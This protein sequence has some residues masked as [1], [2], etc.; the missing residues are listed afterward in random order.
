MMG[1]ENGGS[2]GILQAGYCG[3]VNATLRFNSTRPMSCAAYIGGVNDLLG[4]E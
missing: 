3:R 1:R 4:D 2:P